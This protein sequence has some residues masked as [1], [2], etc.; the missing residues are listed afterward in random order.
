[1]NTLT[2]Y[3]NELSTPSENADNTNENSWR[4]WAN[5]LHDTLRQIRNIR[6]GTKFG[7]RHDQLSN[8]QFDKSFREC[9]KIWLG[10]DQHRNLIQNIQLLNDEIDLLVEIKYQNIVADGLALATLTG[11]WAFSFPIEQSPWLNNTIQ[12]IKSELSEKDGYSQKEHTVSHLSQLDHA[13]NWHQQLQDWG[14]TVS[15]SCKISETES[16]LIVMYSAPREHGYPHV[17]LLNKDSHKTIAKYRVDI[18]ERM[19]G[20]PAYDVE[21]KFFISEHST[22]LINSWDRCQKG[23]HPYKVE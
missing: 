6:P 2:I 17:H 18:F 8:T 4:C 10:R 15:S 14:R 3:F 20:P 12:V 11:S 13:Q 23:G 21:M 9:L 7:F 16:Y 1:M 19:E 22:L 5:Q